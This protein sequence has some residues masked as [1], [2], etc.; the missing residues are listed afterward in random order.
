MAAQFLGLE[1][2]K[3]YLQVEMELRSQSR[4]NYPSNGINFASG[5]SGILQDT[6]KRLVRKNSLP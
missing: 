4:K 6:N 2:Q 1:F 3:P 5:G